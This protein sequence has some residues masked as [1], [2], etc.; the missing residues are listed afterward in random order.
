M[1]GV[2]A[3][4]EDGYEIELWDTMTGKKVHTIP[5]RG[6]Q[7]HGLAFVG[8]LLASGEADTTI[9]LWMCRWLGRNRSG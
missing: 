7:L 3:P 4:N 1:V 8:D 5:S 6:G 9:L 2:A